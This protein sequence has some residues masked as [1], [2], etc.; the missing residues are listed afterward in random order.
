MHGSCIDQHLIIAEV[1]I[2]TNSTLDLAFLGTGK[3]NSLFPGIPESVRL[4]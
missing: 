1:I 2:F 4:F 3:E